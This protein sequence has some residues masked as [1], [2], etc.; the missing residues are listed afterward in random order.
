M[1]YFSSLLIDFFFNKEHNI[2]I[3]IQKFHAPPNMKARKV[4]PCFLPNM[5]GK[6]LNVDLDFLGEKKG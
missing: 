1:L 4:I 6:T 3:T 2:K 5:K